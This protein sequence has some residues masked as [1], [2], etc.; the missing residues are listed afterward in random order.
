MKKK[1]RVHWTRAEISKAFTLRYFSKRAYVYVKNELHYPLPGL[2][3]LQRWAKSIEMRNGV[4]HDVLNLMKLNGEVL[5][6]SE[7][8]TVLMFD[9]VKKHFMH[10][11]FLK[12][13]FPVKYPLIKI[14]PKNM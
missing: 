12:N 8:L 10:L 9:E 11:N 3:S 13:N 4:L 2:S 14:Q 6:N 7:K 5:N 1:K